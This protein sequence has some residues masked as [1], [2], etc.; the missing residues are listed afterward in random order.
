MIQDLCVLAIAVWFLLPILYINRDF[1]YVVVVAAAIWVF[2][3]VAKNP[4]EFVSANWT[5]ISL[6]AVL[7]L[8]IMGGYVDNGWQGVRY[9][10]GVIIAMAV[11]FIGCQMAMRPKYDFYWTAIAILGLFV[12]VAI[13]TTNKLAEDN[14]AARAVVRNSER[15]SE[16]MNENVGGYTLTYFASAI[17]PTLLFLSL[18]L[19]FTGFK[20]RLLRIIAA[21]TFL[22][23]VQLVY[24]AGY[25]IAVVAS[26]FACLVLAIPGRFNRPQYWLALIVSVSILFVMK[27]PIFDQAKSMTKGGPLYSKVQ[28][29]EK[30]SNFAGFGNSSAEG[31]IE[32]YTRSLNSFLDS[33][34]VGTLSTVGTGKHS[35]MLDSF[36]QFGVFGG[37][38]MMIALFLPLYQI[39]QAV[40][41]ANKKLVAAVAICL[42]LHAGLNRLAA[43]STLAVFMFMPFA[44][45]E[46][47]QSNPQTDTNPFY[48]EHEH[49]I[50][51]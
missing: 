14:L 17:C 15:A 20:N 1:R 21:S 25:G 28:S 42:F 50:R 19:P 46:I 23:S 16:L 26:L 22:I 47:R 51:R 2:T 49:I 5:R 4:R 10:I 6:G 29:I 8:L 3:E 40:E 33:P 48:L 35:T 13:T 7:V 31:R 11:S 37:L 44:I 39:Y 12:F 38:A 32:R 9:S 24:R 30:M 36:A 41:P 34:L 18:K 43:G 27:E 45:A